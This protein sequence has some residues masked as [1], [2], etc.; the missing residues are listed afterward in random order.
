METQIS[1]QVEHLQL[2][3]P[4]KVLKYFKIICFRTDGW[5]KYIVESTGQLYRVFQLNFP[6]GKY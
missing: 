1:I 3:P 6:P 5:L 4:Q 2:S